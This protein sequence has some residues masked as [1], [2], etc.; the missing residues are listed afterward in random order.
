MTEFTIIQSGETLYPGNKEWVPNYTEGPTP[1][2]VTEAYLIYKEYG[3][4]V[5][6]INP[7]TGNDYLI[8]WIND[9]A[10]ATAYE[11]IKSTLQ[12]RQTAVDNWHLRQIR[13]QEKLANEL[14]NQYADLLQRLEDVN[15]GRTAAQNQIDN[16][17]E[18][19]D[20]SGMVRELSPYDD[21]SE[22]DTVHD[23][24]M[25]REF[26]LRLTSKVAQQWYKRFSFALKRGNRDVRNYGPYIGGTPFYRPSLKKAFVFDGNNYGQPARGIPM[27]IVDQ[28]L[29]IRL[30][31]LRDLSRANSHWQSFGVP[32]PMADWGEVVND[33]EV[34]EYGYIDGPARYDEEG[35]NSGGT[36]VASY[37]EFLDLFGLGTENEVTG[38]WPKP[39]DTPMFTVSPTSYPV[40][41]RSLLGA[42]AI[43]IAASLILPGVG[44]LAGALIGGA[45]VFVRRQFGNDERR[46]FENKPWNQ[47]YKEDAADGGEQLNNFTMIDEYGNIVCPNIFGLGN[48]P[49]VQSGWSLM[50]GGQLVYLYP[51]WDNAIRR[52]NDGSW[53]PHAHTRR[54]NNGYGMTNKGGVNGNRNGPYGVDKNPDEWRVGVADDGQ[55]K[56]DWAVE[57]MEKVKRSRPNH[58]ARGSDSHGQDSTNLTNNLFGGGYTYF[59]PGPRLDMGD[60]NPNLT[61]HEKR[62]LV[63]NRNSTKKRFMPLGRENPVYGSGDWADAHRKAGEEMGKPRYGYYSSYKNP[64]WPYGSGWYHKRDSDWGDRIYGSKAPPV[65]GPKDM[66]VGLKE[67]G[68][69][70]AVAGAVP[71]L[72]V[73]MAL[74]AVGVLSSDIWGTN[75][76]MY[77][78]DLLMRLPHR[79]QFTII[80]DEDN[81]PTLIEYDGTIRNGKELNVGFVDF[82]AR[83]LIHLGVKNRRIGTRWDDGK[84]KPY[85]IAS[86]SWKDR[87]YALFGENPADNFRIVDTTYGDLFG[88]DGHGEGD[89]GSDDGTGGTLDF[90]D[91]SQKIIKSVAEIPIRREV[92]DN[93]LN[94][95]NENMSLMQFLQNIMHPSALGVSTGNIYTMIRPS[96]G[97]GHFQVVQGSKNWA[98]V[99]KKVRGEVKVSEAENRFPDNVMLIDYK[100]SDSLIKSIDMSSKFDP[101]VAGTFERAATSLSSGT[102]TDLMKFLSYGNMA[103]ELKQFLE[104]AGPAENPE[105]Y[106]DVIRV[107]EGDMGSVH[108]DWT[109]IGSDAAQDA[110][111][112]HVPDSMFS[113]FLMQ[114][115][116]RM[117]KLMSVIQTGSGANWATDL[118]ANYMRGCTITIHGTCN[119]QPFNYIY[120]TGVLPSMKGLYMIHNVRDSVTPQ[121]FDTI[122][123]AVLIDPNPS[124]ENKDA[125]NPAG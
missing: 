51:D 97:D 117:T 8:D 57:E 103:V 63:I 76:G 5:G 14:R 98:S 79:G 3:V 1:I 50:S 4:K 2:E 107:D 123:E 120:I 84:I 72:N 39:S 77:I 102:K 85:T 55:N 10:N 12:T 82:V 33:K 27:T 36:H 52:Q 78:G 37:D 118:L 121:D 116:D 71:G 61:I 13:T 45:S 31:S 80:N 86:H 104:S 25:G 62:A 26:P 54:L 19:L 41:G 68:F 87:L 91:F 43:G 99:G 81:S 65:T 70:Y 90:A 21:T 89:D 125:E 59:V 109:R 83:E 23:T 56:K 105:L 108:V 101:G 73:V 64:Q 67:A 22:I 110:E 11:R 6:V 114:D 115:P 96:G 15:Q 30:S 74:S 24:W 66:G 58:I 44:A 28:Q 93:L 20:P 111:K 17:N 48:E 119:I 53:I 29:L 46:K 112:I 113:K 88:P 95:T 38:A 40:G 92:V 47:I 100:A 34:N 18:F 75:Y 49:Y 122:I 69:A 16:L 32:L 124:D 106:K 35:R 7:N 9:P 60:H 42:A 94:K